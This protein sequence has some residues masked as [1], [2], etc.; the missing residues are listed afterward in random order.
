LDRRRNKHLKNQPCISEHP[1]L[2]PNYPT[3]VAL[4]MNDLGRFVNPKVNNGNCW[5]YDIS[6]GYTFS[7]GQVAVPVGGKVVNINLQ[8]TYTFNWSKVRKLLVFGG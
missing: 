6:H 3:P 1:V 7:G 5:A 4:A 8:N 2:A